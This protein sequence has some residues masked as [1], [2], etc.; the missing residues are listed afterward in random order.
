MKSGTLTMMCCRRLSVL[1]RCD[2]ALGVVWTC[3]PVATLS[4][5]FFR[6]RTLF[7]E[8]ANGAGRIP[9]HHA[10]AEL[11]APPLPPCRARVGRGGK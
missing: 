8:L 11:Q 7:L 9:K 1:P 3:L 10:A 2:D 5:A 4:L 6:P